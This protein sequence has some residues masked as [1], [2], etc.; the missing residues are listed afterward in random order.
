MPFNVSRFLVRVRQFWTRK[1]LVPVLGISALIL[2]GITSYH[3]IAS[4]FNKQPVV[5]S[6]FMFFNDGALFDGAHQNESANVHT[7][8]FRFDH[9]KR[10]HHRHDK[11]H[12]EHRWRE[13]REF[14]SEDRFFRGLPLEDDQKAMELKDK[15]EALR[16]ESERLSE[17]KIELEKH[18]L[19]LRSDDDD[20]K[21]II[22]KNG[23]GETF[24]IT[25]NGKKIEIVN[26]GEEI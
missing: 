16:K 13:Y 2:F 11:R 14:N 12:R 17:Q 24:E 6:H 23:D 1:R 4:M 5:A 15:L 20:D 25:I 7:F 8:H 22:M 19:K 21:V 3:S 26:P 10:W 9:N 18:V